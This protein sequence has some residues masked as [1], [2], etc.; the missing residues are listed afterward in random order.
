MNNWVQTTI[1]FYTTISIF[2]ITWGL[3]R[4]V[5]SSIIRVVSSGK[6]SF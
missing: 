4:R 2:A 6:L 1:Q 5:A 3:G